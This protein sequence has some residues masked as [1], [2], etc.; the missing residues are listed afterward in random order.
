MAASGWEPTPHFLPLWTGD[1]WVRLKGW[2]DE[3]N[4]VNVI[5]ILWLPLLF[6]GYPSDLSFSIWQLFIVRFII[7]SVE[8]S[9]CDCNRHHHHHC[10]HHR[11]CETFLRQTES[12]II[13]RT[14]PKTSIP[15]PKNMN[16][17]QQRLQ[18]SDV[19]LFME[20]SMANVDVHL[21]FNLKRCTKWTRNLGVGL[22][23]L[24]NIGETKAPESSANNEFLKTK[25]SFYSWRRSIPQSK[26]SSVANPFCSSACTAPSSWQCQSDGGENNGEIYTAGKNFMDK[27]H[28]CLQE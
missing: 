27:F 14:T 24:T 16:W 21:T 3:M 20:Q 1:S 9:L 23:V 7:I 26:W 15:R 17:E 4:N 2:H 6:G 5:V 18:N 10:H 8:L 12:P 28:L 11:H 22:L 13:P 19:R 25:N